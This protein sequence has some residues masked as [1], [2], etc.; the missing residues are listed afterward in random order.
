MLICWVGLIVAIGPIPPIIRVVLL[1]LA[2]RRAVVCGRET[3]VAPGPILM[4]IQR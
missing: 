4:A 1:A 2:A 3:F